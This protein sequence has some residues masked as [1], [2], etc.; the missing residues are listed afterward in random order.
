MN[1]GER[2]LAYVI[3]YARLD[4]LVRLY[5]D[6]LVDK[7]HLISQHAAIKRELTEEAGRD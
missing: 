6:G 3:A 4:E 5:L 1:E 7:N 2:R